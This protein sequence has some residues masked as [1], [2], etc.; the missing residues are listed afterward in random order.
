[1]TIPGSTPDHPGTGGQDMR[2]LQDPDD[3]LFPDVSGRWPPGRAG[4]VIVVDQLRGWQPGSPPSLA[5]LLDTR[6]GPIRQPEP[7]LEAEP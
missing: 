6:P 2:E 3:L 1:M 7:G 5:E 4:Y